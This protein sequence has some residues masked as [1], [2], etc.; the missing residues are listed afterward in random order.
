MAE[1][2]TDIERCGYCHTSFSSDQGCAMCTSGGTYHLAKCAWRERNRDQ[3][4][5]NKPSY[6]LSRAAG[7]L[8]CAVQ[9]TGD[10]NTAE[11]DAMESRLDELATQYKEKGH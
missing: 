7:A 3:L 4:D 10:E 5:T 1:T 9:L 2:G 11:I 8:D 6:W